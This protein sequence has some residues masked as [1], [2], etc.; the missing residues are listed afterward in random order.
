M[1][2]KNKQTELEQNLQN[3]VT[4]ND[5][6]AGQDF[7][8]DQDE[9]V[10]ESK[11]NLDQCHAEI[12]LW[13]DQCRRVSAEFENFKKRTERDQARWSENAKESVLIE[14]LSIVDDFDRALQQEN[15]D[16]DG[17]SMM[18]QS[19]MKILEK[20]GV[21]AMDSYESFDPNFHE[22]I[23]QVESDVHESG[24]I[25]DVLAKGFMV[26]NRVLRPAKVSVAQ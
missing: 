26:K 18:Y 6:S 23:M 8:H 2:E 20:H 15:G 12:S 7:N 22:A 4:D 13:K 1:S 11:D 10:N 24:Q 14:L 19:F 3:D 5:Q 17:I 16:N 9:V 25:V 21:V